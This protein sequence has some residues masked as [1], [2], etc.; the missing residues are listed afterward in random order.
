ML[1]VSERERAKGTKITKV[2]QR[3]KRELKGQRQPKLD[4]ETS[5]SLRQRPIYD[6]G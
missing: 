4:K 6:K 2:K 3:D 5:L 1:D